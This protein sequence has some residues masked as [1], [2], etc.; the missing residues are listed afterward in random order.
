MED[1]TA[2]VML[3]AEGKRPL[4]KR[5]QRWEDNI[6]MELGESVD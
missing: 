3:K 6:K 2:F 4:G 5:R 1:I